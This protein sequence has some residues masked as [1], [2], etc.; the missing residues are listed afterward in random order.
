VF[1][2]FFFEKEFFIRFKIG[3][4]RGISQLEQQQQTDFT[5]II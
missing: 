2:F 1:F 4:H 3:V 5:I